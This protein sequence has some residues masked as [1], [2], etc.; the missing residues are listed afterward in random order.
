M[1]VAKFRETACGC[2][3]FISCGL[4]ENNAWLGE[5]HS[6]DHNPLGKNCQKPKYYDCLDLA[7]ILESFSSVRKVKVLSIY[8]DPFWLLGVSLRTVEHRGA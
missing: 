5:W 8:I 6:I 2:M 3:P 7:S 4:P 1:G